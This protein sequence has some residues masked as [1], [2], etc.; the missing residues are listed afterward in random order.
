L[1]LAYGVGLDWF[2]LTVGEVVRAVRGDDHR[3]FNG[4]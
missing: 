1:E 4:H 3:P 2:G